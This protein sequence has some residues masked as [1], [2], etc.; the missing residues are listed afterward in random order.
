[1]TA[2]WPAGRRHQ[3]WSVAALL[4]V[5]GIALVLCAKSMDG[6]SQAW[7]IEVGAAIGLL[8]PLYFLEDLLRGRVEALTRQLEESAQSYGM[9]R[10]LL[11]S[12][13][14]VGRT[15]DRDPGG[16]PRGS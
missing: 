4:V 2:R 1:M 9:I 13:A 5:V 15:A 7:R 11:P 10:R 8:G 6:W 14:S 12:V 3:R 16:D